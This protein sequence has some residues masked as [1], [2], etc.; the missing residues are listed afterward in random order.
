MSGFNNLIVF[1]CDGT[2][3]DSQHM[4]VDAMH[5]TF[6]RAKVGTVE[7]H[8][9]RSII[10]LSLEEAMANLLPDHESE[11]H[12]ELAGLYKKVFYE[13][14]SRTSFEPDPLYKGTRD[15]LDQL[16]GAGYILGVATG[17]SNRGLQRVIDQHD[18]ADLFVSLQ[19]ADGHPSKPHPSMIHTAMADA[20]AAPETTVMIGDTSFDMM[21][22]RNAGAHALGVTWGYHSVPELQESG[23]HHIATDYSQIPQII[24]TLLEA[25]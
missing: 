20:G 6:L 7:D 15:V 11:K 24:K 13:L 22:A 19:T 18:L 8:A 25:G 4:I 14:R 9:V 21:M 17:N 16:S 12:I 23:A 1:D 3:V 2:L 10:G 5:T